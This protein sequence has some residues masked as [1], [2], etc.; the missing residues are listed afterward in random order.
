MFC[1]R[2]SPTFETSRGANSLK[3]LAIISLILQGSGKF[4]TNLQSR[5]NIFA[6]VTIESLID[7]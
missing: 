4:Q 3:W 6:Y 1:I 7:R 5:Q 2:L